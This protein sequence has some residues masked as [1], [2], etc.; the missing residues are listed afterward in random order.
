MHLADLMQEVSLPLLARLGPVLP[1]QGQAGLHAG[2]V[3]QGLRREVLEPFLC[4][5]HLPRLQ[6]PGEEHGPGLGGHGPVLTLRGL[7]VEGAD[8]LGV[9]CVQGHSGEGGQTLQG[10]GGVQR[11]QAAPGELLPLLLCQGEG[12]GQA[13]LSGGAV[14]GLQEGGH[15]LPGHL[16]LEC[17]QVVQ[18]RPQQPGQGGQQGDLRQGGVC[19][20]KLRIWIQINQFCR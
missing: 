2:L 9:L 10:Q 20:P 14:E 7:A 1:G 6:G 18:I 17:Q 13:A 12:S 19:F 4:L 8:P 16:L 3:I 15:L 11:Q 5:V